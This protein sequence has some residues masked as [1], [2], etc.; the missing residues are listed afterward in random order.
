MAHRFGHADGSGDVKIGE[1]RVG[2]L[3]FSTDS[4]RMEP[5]PRYRCGQIWERVASA[6]GVHLLD[7]D[8][9]HQ[10]DLLLAD[11]LGRCMSQNITNIDPFTHATHC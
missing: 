11:V 1:A 10:L 3:Q 9:A 4:K 2:L 6:N 8:H 5:R 7:S